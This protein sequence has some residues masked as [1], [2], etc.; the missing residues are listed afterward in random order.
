[1]RVNPRGIGTRPW[2]DEDKA[3]FAELWTAGASMTAIATTLNRTIGACD[4]RRRL[5]N[6]PERASDNAG[7]ITRRRLAR[8]G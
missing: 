4:I 6:L 3:R 7:W 2:S 1:M 5:M 8:G